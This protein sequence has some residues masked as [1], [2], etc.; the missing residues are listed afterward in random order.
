[1]SD[2]S[3]M[4]YE[5]LSEGAEPLSAAI[6]IEDG[7]IVLH[8]RGG[9]I[10]SYSE[11]NRDYSEALRLILTRTLEARAVLRGI[12]VDSARTRHLPGADRIILASSEF[13]GSPSD[14]FTLISRRMQAIGRSSTAQTTRGNSNKRIRIEVEGKSRSQIERMLSAH[15]RRES[16]SPRGRL[17]ADTLYSVTAE[18]VRE[19][20]LDAIENGPDPAFQESRQYDLIAGDGIRLPPKAVFGRAATLALGFRVLPEHFSAGEGEPCFKILRAAGF[21]IVPKG[22]VERAVPVLSRED[23]SWAE[24][25][26][27]LVSHLKRERHRGLPAAKR[28]EFRRIHGRLFCE[29]CGLDPVIQYGGPEGEAC[30]EVHHALP[31]AEMAPGHETRLSDVECLCANCHRVVHSQMSQRSRFAGR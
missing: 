6:D 25:D 19:A 10:G 30:I 18:H 28:A 2:V 15:I 22:E 7:A 24:G 16:G 17:S 13:V 29:L 8:S 23:L 31:L 21:G 14:L 9:T 27:R 4:V 1:M 20:V 3:P 5:I 26:P 11:R 12:W